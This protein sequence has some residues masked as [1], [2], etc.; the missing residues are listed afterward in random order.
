MRIMILALVAGLAI[1][2]TA[3][4]SDC[5]PAS[6]CGDKQ[7]C[8]ED[9]GCCQRCGG[10]MV[11]K[12]VCEKKKVKKTVWVVKCEPICP[13]LPGCGK[14]YHPCAKPSCDEKAPGCCTEC[15]KAGGCGKNPCDSLS[16]RRYVPPKCA[17]PKTVKKLTKKEVKC[18]IPVYKCVPVCCNGC[19]SGCGDP[20]CCEEGCGGAIK[21]EETG[22]PATA[23]EAPA[24]DATTRL[25]NRPIIGISYLQ[26]L[27]LDR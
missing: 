9:H 16:K 19:R 25:Q 26:A 14:G 10:K 27:K 1:A 11:C 17:K 2:T 23:P 21:V 7:G 18:E 15:G 5:C 6:A 24:P 12:L 8:C 3:T 22:P 20:G 13:V 4:A